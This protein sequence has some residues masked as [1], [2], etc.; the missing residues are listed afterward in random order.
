MTTRTISNHRYHQ[1][2]LALAAASPGPAWLAELR[3]AGWERFS[4]LGFPTARRGNGALEV[5]RRR[6]HRAGGLCLSFYKRSERRV[7]FGFSE[8]SAN[9]AFDQSDDE[10]RRHLGS[11][12]PMDDD[13]FTALNTAFLRDVAI[14]RVPRRR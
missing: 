2:H 8:V 9:S 11:L 5:H 6:P 1:D 4:A 13:G 12:A 10:I 3:A 14:V 7:D